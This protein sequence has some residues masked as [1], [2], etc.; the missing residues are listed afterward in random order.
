M[1]IGDVGDAYNGET[2]LVTAETNFT[3]ANVDFSVNMRNISLTAVNDL[4]F[5]T[6]RDFN[7]TAQRDINLRGDVIIHDRVEG[8]LR[9][10]GGIGAG[11]VNCQSGAVCVPSGGFFLY[12]SDE[13]LKENISQLDN[14]LDRLLQLRGYSF[15]WK[16][17]GEH[18]V[19]L[20]AQEVEAVYPD[21]VGGNQ[22]HKMVSYSNLVAPIIEAIRELKVENDS[23]RA[24]LAEVRQTIQ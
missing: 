18:S 5:T 16:S 12:S 10:S 7:I 8:N 21:L 20:I 2:L 13:R 19:G 23:L 22:D 14:S 15:D 11:G 1:T 9:V 3:N 24:E 17:N 4:G 6:G